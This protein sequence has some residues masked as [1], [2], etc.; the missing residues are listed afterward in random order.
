MERRNTKSDPIAEAGMGSQ[1]YG[2]WT[3]INGRVEKRRSRGSETSP[4]E[5]KGN[6]TGKVVIL[7]IEAKGLESDATNLLR[8][9]AVYGRDTERVVNST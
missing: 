3:K 4:G 9:R 6:A 1:G 7:Y 5:E 8:R 2:E